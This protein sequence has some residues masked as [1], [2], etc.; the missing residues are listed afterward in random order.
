[1]PDRPTVTPG[2]WITIRGAIGLDAVVSALWPP[3]SGGPGDIEA[4]Y[5]DDRN[6]AINVDVRWDG[7]GWT[8]AHDFVD[9][10]YAD[11]YDRLREYV[12]I[13]RR[14]RYR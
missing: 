3:D 9:G 11:K 2:D 8:F 6:R 14:G 12:G 13:L 4:V 7:Q 10:G 1:M 5:L